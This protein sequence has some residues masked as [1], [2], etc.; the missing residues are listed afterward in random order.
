MLVVICNAFDKRIKLHYQNMEVRNTTSSSNKI[1]QNM[2]AIIN[3][4]VW[5]KDSSQIW[6]ANRRNKVYL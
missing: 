5:A 1:I 6:Q 3:S 4:R 2:C